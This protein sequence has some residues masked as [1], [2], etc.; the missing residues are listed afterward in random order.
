M[1]KSPVLTLARKELTIMI[2]AP[3]TYVIAVVFLLIN[4]WLFVSPLFQMNQST[5]DTFSRPLPLIFTFLVPALT[6]RAFSEEFKTGTIEY[7]GTLPI[8]DYEIVL[9]KYLAV[10][11]MIGMLIAFTLFYP[12]V[13]FVIGRPDPGQLVGTYVSILCLASFFAAIG[14]WASAS[15]RNQVVAFIVGFFVCFLF[16]LLDRVADFLPGFLVSFVRGLSVQTHF[17]ALARGVLDTRDL[18]YWASGTFFFL[19]ASLT[20]VQSKK[21]R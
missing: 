18:I 10:L 15:T 16:F 5:L 8:E 3:A 12:L 11:G 2:H 17:D 19:A 14:L 7:L 6:M 4:G 20:V 13:L 9:G 21:W 1:R